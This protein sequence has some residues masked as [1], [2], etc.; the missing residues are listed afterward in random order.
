MWSVFGV[1]GGL[2]VGTVPLVARAT[3]AGDLPR[4]RE[5]AR[6]ALLLSTLLATIVMLGG[7]AT[8]E[9][10][11]AWLG[12]ENPAVAALSRDYLSVA[13]A[14]FLPMFLATTAAMVLAAT[15][16]TQTPFRAGLVANAVNVVLS[17]LLVFGF[18]FG[19]LG[20]I[21]AMGVRGAAMGSVCAFTVEAII[22]LL[23]LRM[24][25]GFGLSWRRATRL[26]A[27]LVAL[28]R[29]S[30]P[31]VAERAVI[32]TGYL[33]FVAVITA[34]GPLVMATNQALIT[35]ESICFLG[36]EG[37]G[38]AAAT[39]VGQSLGRRSEGSAS[40]AGWL[41][42]GL[43]ASLLTL[44]GLLL[45]ALSPWALGWFAG[46]GTDPEPLVQEASRAFPFLVAAQPFMGLS[47]V[48]AQ[49][50]RGAGDTRSP[51]LAAVVGGLVLRVSLAYW[52]G[53]TQGF[54]ILG[55]WIASLVDWVFRAVL[56][57]TI[58]ARGRWKTIDV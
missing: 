22:L 3:G 58:F 4:A 49:A 7:Y 26:T 19:A 25:S 39:V 51:L 54:G 8:I 42:A 34:L 50:L 37:F 18:D 55:I 29:I 11:V 56:L 38:V 9:P 40:T 6:A 17:V 2:L 33:A 57:S 27:S 36:A 48:L 21:E 15:G 53:V 52:L 24:P 43:S 41:A 23:A 46:P 1:F 20:S 14:S 28:T 30:L 5:V 13:L 45:W 32:H 16:N 31:A 35:L 47:V 12:P 10:V 44:F